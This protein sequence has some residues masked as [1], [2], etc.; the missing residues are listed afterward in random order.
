[1]API[2]DL[3]VAA[4]CYN[5]STM[6]E[7]GIRTLKSRLSELVK[8]AGE[9]ETVVVTDRGRPVADLV[10]HRSTELPPD[11]AEM[12]RGGELTLATEPPRL[13]KHR[14]R[15]KP[16]SSLT[17]ILLQQRRESHERLLR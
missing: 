17:E 16:G 4:K 7:V 8:R 3:N 11:L 5:V 14:A 10:P 9:G 15:M 12:L 6:L 2:P 1:M 13:P